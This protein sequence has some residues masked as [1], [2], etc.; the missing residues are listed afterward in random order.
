MTEAD[1]FGCRNQIPFSGEVQIEVQL[2]V[3]DATAA[4]RH[5]DAAAN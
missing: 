4:G 5:R 1:S 2:R 3:E